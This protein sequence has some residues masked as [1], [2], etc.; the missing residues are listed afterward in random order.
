MIYEDSISIDAPTD[1]VFAV[2]SNVSDWASWDPETL[3]SSIDGPF[4]VGTTGKIKPEGEPETNIKI[5]ELT[6]DSSFTVECHIPLCKMEFVHELEAVDNKTL[7]TNKIVLSGA[8]SSIFGFLIGS[9]LRKGME[10]SLHGLKEH[11][12]N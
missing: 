9:K 4:E 5:T 11:M 1:A 2:Y 10:L 3:S 7:V 8:L 12:E 6:T